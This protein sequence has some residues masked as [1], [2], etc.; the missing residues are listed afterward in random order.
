LRLMLCSKTA[1]LFEK[2]GINR[3]VT[4]RTLNGS[5]RPSQKIVSALKLRSCYFRTKQSNNVFKVKYSLHVLIALALIFARI[6]S[7]PSLS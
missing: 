6:F 4:Y 3:S 7:V 5:R 2:T 1:S